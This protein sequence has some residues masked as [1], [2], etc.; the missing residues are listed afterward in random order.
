MA[1]STIV[2]LFGLSVATVS[3]VPGGNNGTVKIDGIEFDQHVDNEP[4]VGCI[5]HVNWFNFDASVT[6]H[7][8]FSVQP[9]SGPFETILED[10]VL[11]LDN[12][13]AGAANDFSGLEEYN[14]GP[15]LTPYFE[16]PNQGFH[17][18]LTINTP[19]S[20]GAD[21]KH[22]VFWVA[23]CEE[24]T[25][26][27][28]PTPEGSQGGSTSTPSP[29]PEGSQGGGTGTPDPSRTPEG[30]QAGATGTPAASLP[31]TA[32]G[33]TSSGTLAT[34]LFGAVLISA[35]GALAYANVVAVRR[36]R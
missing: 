5:F 7:V 25:Q 33:S 14:L 36:R 20:N 10:D 11:L 19:V 17:V 24:P 13:P 21:V 32:F 23:G 27:P 15:Y 16:H 3:A 4:H 34:M 2:A 22:K 9:P 1:I 18:K 30:S 31:N 29:T 28:S 26:T 6:S 12:D 35:L 8:T